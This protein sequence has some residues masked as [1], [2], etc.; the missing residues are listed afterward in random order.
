VRNDEAAG[1]AKSSH[2]VL[3]D[4]AEVEIEHYRWGLK[5]LVI[6]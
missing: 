6:L 5:G 2:C 1:L 3:P 4:V